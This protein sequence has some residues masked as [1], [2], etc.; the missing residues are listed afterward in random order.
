MGRGRGKP[1]A[2]W[3]TEPDATVKVRGETVRLLLLWSEAGE[4]TVDASR[5]HAG[6]V[7]LTRGV[8]GET[9]R[10]KAAAIPVTE[11]PVIVELE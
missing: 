8:S 11:E 4:R 1:G 5:M 7:K 9:R 2:E 10:V 3:Y 6:E